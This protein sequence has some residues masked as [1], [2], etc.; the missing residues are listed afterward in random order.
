MKREIYVTGIVKDSKC[1]LEKYLFSENER[2][3]AIIDELE[4]EN[5]HLNIQL[6]QALKDY[7]ELL[8]K[9]DKVI[10]FITEWEKYTKEKRPLEVSMLDLLYIKEI[11]EGE[12]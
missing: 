9:I 3:N 5:K 10:E 6:D 1:N 4:E 8:I 11:L 7:E 2:L 12:K